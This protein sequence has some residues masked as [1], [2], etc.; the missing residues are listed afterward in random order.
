L[1]RAYRGKVYG[2]TLPCFFV[3]FFCLSISKKVISKMVLKC[4]QSFAECTGT[5]VYHDIR[6]KT[7]WPTSGRMSFYL[8]FLHI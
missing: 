6:D 4:A 5:T 7:P 2:I 8:Q 1:R 3:F